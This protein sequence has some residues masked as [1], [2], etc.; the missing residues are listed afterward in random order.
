MSP[1]ELLQQRRDEAYE[2]FRQA[3]ETIRARYPDIIGPVTM[4]AP[5]RGPG[6]FTTRPVTGDGWCWGEYYLTGTGGVWTKNGE[7]KCSMWGKTHGCVDSTT[8]CSACNKVNP[9]GCH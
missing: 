6:S 1:R 7:G 5:K 4:A 8:Q 2:L 9:G 3:V